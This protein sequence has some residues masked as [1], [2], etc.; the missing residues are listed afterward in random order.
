MGLFDK[1]NAG[2]QEHQPLHIFDKTDCGR[3]T[4]FCEVRGVSAQRIIDAV[5][6]GTWAEVE[7][8]TT[9]NVPTAEANTA[10][11]LDGLII[12]GYETKFGKTNNNGERY[13][14]DCLDDFVQNYYIKNKLNL[15]VTIQ[16]RDDLKHVVGRVLL[17]E[18]NSVGFYFVAYI[19]RAIAEY[20]DILVRIREGILQGMSKEGWCDWKDTDL[21]Y[22]KD[23]SFDY[24]LYKKMT[25]TGISIVTTPANGIPFEKVQQIKNEL[26]YHKQNAI[27][28]GNAAE[29]PFTKMFNHN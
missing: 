2:A 14:K 21:F 8:L 25:L 5:K 16:H 19:P 13:E 22:K 26:Q 12:K 27:V 15:P 24:V 1:N 23:G 20:N 11:K 17:I 18:V 29:T 6:L 9:E 28:N 10:D 7:K 4:N 3:I